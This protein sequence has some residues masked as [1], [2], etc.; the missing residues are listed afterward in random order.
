LSSVFLEVSEKLCGWTKFESPPFRWT[1]NKF[2]LFQKL[3]GRAKGVLK[4]LKDRHCEQSG[5][6]PLAVRLCP[7]RFNSRS[8]TL[9]SSLCLDFAHSSVIFRVPLS[10]LKGQHPERIEEPEDKTTFDFTP[11]HEPRTALYGCPM[12][13]YLKSDGGKRFSLMARGEVHRI[14][15]CKAPAL[16]LVPEALAPPN[17]C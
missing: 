12:N 1:Q 16:S 8:S 9:L 13:G 5:V 4:E 11:N 10:L 2:Y 3:S 15:L 7:F 14:M 6:P 17:G